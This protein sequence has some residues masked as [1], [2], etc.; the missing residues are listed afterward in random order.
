[1]TN[2][3]RQINSQNNW[4]SFVSQF[5]QGVHL[6]GIYGEANTS[7]LI[8]LVIYAILWF[9]LGQDKQAECRKYT[10]EGSTVI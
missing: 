5:L 2:N 7:A 1:M 4:D 6:Y 3:Q 8:A 10:E 9:S